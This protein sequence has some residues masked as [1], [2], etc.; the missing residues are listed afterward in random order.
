[1]FS[2]QS[3]QYAHLNTD[4]IR[5]EYTHE[6]IWCACR[7]RQRAEDIKDGAYTQFT[8]DWCRMFHRTVMVRCKH[9]TDAGLSD[10]LCNL[11][12]IQVDVNTQRFSTSAL[13][14]DEETLRPPCLATRAPAA[15]VTNIE[16][17]EILKVFAPSP[18]VPTISIIFSVLT[19]GTLVENS[20]MTCAAAVISPMLSFDAQTY[21]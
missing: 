11:F 9:K 3:L 16:V 13:P 2:A 18:P 5:M 20:R 21:R 15:A 12:W 10:G 1:M 7:I 8:P 19:N 6:N 17:V 14:D 4:Q